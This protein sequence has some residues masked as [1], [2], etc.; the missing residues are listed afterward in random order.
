[1]F[2][3]CGNKKN[4]VRPSDKIARRFKEEPE[5]RQGQGR[6]CEDIMNELNPGTT[7]RGLPLTVDQERE[8]EHYIR[9][10][11]R[12]GAPWDTPELRA[13]IADMLNPPELVRD[14]SQ[15]VDESTDAERDTARGE[16]S[17]D[18]DELRY[19][20]DERDRRH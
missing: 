18:V 12:C 11:Q 19:E 2:F 10:R 14:D 7:F 13:M 1:M 6:S 20:R 5:P 15:S 16:E 8:I 4:G 17:T 9:A 3:A